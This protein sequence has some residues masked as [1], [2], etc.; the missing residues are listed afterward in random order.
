MSLPIDFSYRGILMNVEF[1][2]IVLHALL[3]FDFLRVTRN[4]GQSS[5]LL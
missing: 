5:L 2:N 3:Y 4:A 1:S